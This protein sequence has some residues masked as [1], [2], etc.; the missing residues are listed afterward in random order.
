MALNNDL[1]IKAGLDSVTQEEHEDIKSTFEALAEILAAYDSASV[2]ADAADFEPDN[3]IDNVF[4]INLSP[5]AESLDDSWRQRLKSVT[6]NV[7]MNT[8][9]FNDRAFRTLNDKVAGGQIPPKD[10]I[11]KANYF[12][13]VISHLVTNAPW[14]NTHA[15]MLQDKKFTTR[16]EEFHKALISHFTQG[17]N[18][19]NNVV[20]KFEGFLAKVQN[21]IKDSST[22]PRDSISI[23]IY[24]V[25][26]VKD[27]VRQE[28]RPSVRTISFKPS[29]NL[30]VYVKDKNNKSTGSEVNVDFEYV[31]FDG[32]FNNDLFERSAKPALMRIGPGPAPIKPLGI[33]FD[34]D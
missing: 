13:K 6:E 31:Q 33:T 28:W 18:L 14:I 17:L 1:N 23:Y 30:G 11:K 9:F 2:L 15:V 24:A 26:Y 34:S 4:Y 22:S 25:V 27:E 8:G 3:L 20:D 21:T 16:K 19:P 5:N 32:A 10:E 7:D 12:A 29:Q